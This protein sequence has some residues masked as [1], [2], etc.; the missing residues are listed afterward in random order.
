[1]LWLVIVTHSNLMVV[2]AGLIDLNGYLFPIILAHIEPPAVSGVSH[3]DWMTRLKLLVVYD[4]MNRTVM[5][6]IYY[7]H[8]GDGQ[9]E[10]DDEWDDEWE[11]NPPVRT[12][13]FF[14]AGSY[15]EN[16]KGSQ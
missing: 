2:K 6:V 4:A 11:H 15:P 9:D 12:S 7:Q 10:W 1:M 8:N 16:G 5:H 13:F 14:H 3:S